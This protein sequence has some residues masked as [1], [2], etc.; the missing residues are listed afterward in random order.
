MFH[1]LIYFLFS[2][3][4]NSC[5]ADAGMVLGTCTHW[6][7]VAEENLFP[8]GVNH[9]CG[10]ILMEE[11]LDGSAAGM[12]LRNE[13]LKPPLILGSHCLYCGVVFFAE[14]TAANV[15]LEVLKHLAGLLKRH[16]LFLLPFSFPFV[17]NAMGVKTCWLGL[18]CAIF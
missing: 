17:L 2:P 3:V 10:C 6:W 18:S 12:Q 15:Q 4:V 16:L 1:H 5:Q 14:L 13:A 9:A 11:R 8:L 7:A